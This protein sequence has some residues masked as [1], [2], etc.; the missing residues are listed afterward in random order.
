MSAYPKNDC[1]ICIPPRASSWD[2]ING[3]RVGRGG[4][5]AGTDSVVASLVPV[6][7]LPS[8]E[9]LSVDAGGSRMRTKRAAT[10][11]SDLHTSA[12]LPLPHA[13]DTYRCFQC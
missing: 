4:A 10:S 6:Q 13:Q 2:Q 9:T 1:N 7:Q 3:G 5:G 8:S 12:W 11:A